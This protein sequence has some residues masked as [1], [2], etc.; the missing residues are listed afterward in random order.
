M[1]QPDIDLQISTEEELKGYLAQVKAREYNII[2]DTEELTRI[3]NAIL[4]GRLL[5]DSEKPENAL[6]LLS[7]EPRE[8]ALFY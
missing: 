5:N 1:Y 3:E 7:N 2:L 4:E 8:C 6:S